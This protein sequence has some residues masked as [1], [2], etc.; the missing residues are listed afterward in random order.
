MEAIVLCMEMMFVRN[1]YP[2]SGRTLMEAIVLDGD[3]VRT[4]AGSNS[5]NTNSFIVATAA[6]QPS[7][8]YLFQ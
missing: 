2:E 1:G 6:L 4:S 3:D 8:N 5:S 7:C